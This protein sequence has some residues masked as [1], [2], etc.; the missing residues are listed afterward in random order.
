MPTRPRPATRARPT[1]PAASAAPAPVALDGVF[2]LQDWLPYEF[3]LIAGR[4][5]ALLAGMYQERFKLTVPGWRVLAV[6][7][8][9]AP[10]SAKQVGERTAMSPV[11][12]SRAVAHLHEL[13]MVLRSSNAQD[14]RQVLL[15]PSR[16]G[17]E[18]YRQVIPLAMKIEQRLL[19]GLRPAELHALRRAIAALSQRAL[20][21]LPDPQDWHTLVD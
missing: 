9:E 1:D 21:Q 3:S 8:D 12:V 15:R 11:N 6:L 20:T 4:V 18:A 5:S 16:K 19:Q 14:Q 13:G 2:Q 7:N 10:L 17:Q